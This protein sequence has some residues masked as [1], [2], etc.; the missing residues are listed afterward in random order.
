MSHP[1]WQSDGCWRAAEWSRR[2]SRSPR[3][4]L[5]LAGGFA[6]N[7]ITRLVLNQPPSALGASP[8]QAPWQ[9]HASTILSPLKTILIG[10]INWL[11]TPNNALLSTVAMITWR[12][13][14][15]Y[16]LIILTG[17]TTNLASGRVSCKRCEK[18]S[19]ASRSPLQ[20]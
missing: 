10:P 1:F 6:F 12:F 7:F 8:D 19:T 16:M 4:A 20:N 18:F 3:A 5:R 13:A 11:G 14:G 9:Q 2:K 15:F 17:L